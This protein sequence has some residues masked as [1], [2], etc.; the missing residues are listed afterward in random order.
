MSLLA[1]ARGLARSA[2]LDTVRPACEHAFVRWD[3]PDDRRGA[4]GARCRATATPRSSAAS[5]RPR[6]STPAST[7]CGRSRR[8]TA[9]RRRRRCRSAGRSTRTGAAAMRACTA[10]PGPPT[11]TS[12]ST[13]AAT[14]RSEIVVKVN[15]PEVLRAELS[16]P[17][18]T[19]EHVAMGTNTDPYQWVEGR[20]RLMPGIWEA[21]RDAAT[22]CSVLTKSPLV[23]RDLAGAAGD[24][25][26]DERQR[27]PLG[28]DARREAPGGRPSRTR[29]SPTSAAR[30]GRGAQPRPGSRRGSSIAPLMPGINDA[31]EQVEAILSA[32]RRRR[33]DLGRRDHAAPARRGAR[34]LPRLA[35][36][37][38]AGPR[39]ALRG[40]L[41]ARRLR[42]EGRAGPHRGR[43]AP[44]PD[45]L[46]VLHAV[47]ARS[48]GRRR[49]RRRPARPIAAPVAPRER[50]H[51]LRAGATVQGALF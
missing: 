1:R 29:R 49:S 16:R 14:S 15:A 23:L 31:P 40:A 28:P 24:R 41:R 48:P 7:R 46:P 4:A 36:I 11:S 43:P 3:E 37:P 25:G 44:R 32:R 2:I 20:Y 47:R 51:A 34:D 17:S 22:P 26:G 13:P 6:R 19:R 21:L 30:G 45:A 35:A 10:S 12:T 38:A 42:A 5:T 8:S 27:E 33:R 18:W 9:S 39:G 50:R